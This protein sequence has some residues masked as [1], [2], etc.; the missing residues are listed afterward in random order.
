MKK[1]QRIGKS[2][3]YFGRVAG[4]SQFFPAPYPCHRTLEDIH[5]GLILENVMVSMIQADSKKI[6]E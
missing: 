6:L 4:W 3:H 1:R 2:K 5:N